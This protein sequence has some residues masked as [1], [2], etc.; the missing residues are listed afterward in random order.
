MI[1]ATKCSDSRSMDYSPDHML[2]LAN[3]AIEKARLQVAANQ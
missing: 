1:F 2:R 3:E